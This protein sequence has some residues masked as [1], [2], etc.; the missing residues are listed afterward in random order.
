MRDPS[1]GELPLA[2]IAEI[3]GTLKDRS[4]YSSEAAYERARE[5]GKRAVQQRLIRFKRANPN[6]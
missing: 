4:A 3:I 2:E 6:A 5:A 1:E